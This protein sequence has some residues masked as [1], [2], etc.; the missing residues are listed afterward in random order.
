MQPDLA[1]RKRNALLLLIIAQIA[2]MSIWFTSTAAIVDMAIEAGL[3]PG[4]LAPLTTA[5]Q[6][7][8]VAG[9]LM[10]AA[11]GLADR[12]EP[13]RLFAGASLIAA[14]A[15]GLTLLT[16][17][18]SAEAVA[19]RAIVG[20]ALAGVYPIGMKMALG[21]ADGDRGFLVGLIVGALTLGSAS[22][23]AV[24][25]LGGADWRMVAGAGSMAAVFAALLMIPLRPGPAAHPGTGSV[26]TGFDWRALGIVWT[27]Q[28][29]RLTFAGYLGHMWELYAFWAWAGFAGGVSFRIA[30]L[31]KAHA[32]FLA[33][34]TAF[35]AVG[36][37][38]LACVGA[39]LL[40]DRIG[41]ARVARWA[42]TG[43]LVAGLCAVA[44]F[45]HAPVLLILAFVLWGITIIPD[46][47][48]FSALVSEFA[49]PGRAGSLLALQTALGFGL[50]A[51]TV[52]LLP[53]AARAMGW[54]LA[55]AALTIGP[56]AGIRAMLC[57]EQRLE[58]QPEGARDV[59]P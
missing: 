32:E 12:L 31:G 38:A 44:A 3:T 39:G 18:G 29:L 25:L 40:A 16:P 46:S 36:S 30:G 43:S 41:K 54:P 35:I 14:A 52:Q 33:S 19:L 53:A 49:P 57:L 8:F 15:N 23:H 45:G 4:T 7:G 1:I 27:D 6:L 48:Q 55:L 9:A 2:A 56:M 34:L 10:L 17:I 42:M 13:R 11:S 28:R 20:A 24:A 26:S 59:R 21:W 5:V 22:P 47:A 58:T 51:L 50:T 37:G